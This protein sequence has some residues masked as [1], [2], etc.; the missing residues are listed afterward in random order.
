MKLTKKQR[1]LVY[2]T[3]LK[4]VCEDP[5]VNR[6]ICDYLLYLLDRSKKMPKKWHLLL[7]VNKMQILPE[8]NKYRPLSGDLYW[9]PRTVEGWETRIGW[10]KQAIKDVKKKMK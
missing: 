1:L 10:I 5:A 3:L 8:L 4:D 9:A 6:G 7:G 2:K